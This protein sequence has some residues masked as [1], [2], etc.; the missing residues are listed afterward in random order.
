[1]AR[2][3]RM[4]PLVLALWIASASGMLMMEDGLCRAYRVALPM[5]ASRTEKAALRNAR[6]DGALLYTP[7]DTSSESNTAVL[8]YQTRNGETDLVKVVSD[9]SD[10][11]FW[12][13]CRASYFSYSPD[14]YTRLP[15]ADFGRFYS[16]CIDEASW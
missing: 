15:A 12:T 8:F 1:M 16:F 5:L 2:T 4:L 11:R 13:S 14:F 7:V 9:A 10:P 3:P 6:P